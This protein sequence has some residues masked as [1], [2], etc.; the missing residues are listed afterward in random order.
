MKPTGLPPPRPKMRNEIHKRLAPPQRTPKPSQHAH[1]VYAPT[2]RESAWLDT[3]G[4]NATTTQQQRTNISTAKPASDH[5]M[6]TTDTCSPTTSTEGTK[7][8]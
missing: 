5:T 8:H 7:S 2:V 3:F 6:T 1:T 4:R